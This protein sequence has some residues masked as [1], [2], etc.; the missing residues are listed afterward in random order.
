MTKTACFLES[1]KS[2]DVKF[3]LLTEK[4]EILKVRVETLQ[5]EILWLNHKL[6]ALEEGNK[7]R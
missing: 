2:L 1:V 5:S 6:D 7:G 4:A 3:R